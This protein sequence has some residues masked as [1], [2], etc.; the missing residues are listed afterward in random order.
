MATTETFVVHLMFILS[1]LYCTVIDYKQSYN[2]TQTR[3]AV[4]FRSHSLFLLLQYLLDHEETVA[5]MSLLGLTSLP[6]PC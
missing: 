4:P 3:G 1:C 5:K 2:F 6:V